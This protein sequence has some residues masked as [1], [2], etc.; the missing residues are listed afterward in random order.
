MGQLCMG[1]KSRSK[2]IDNKVRLK[3]FGH[4][5]EYAAAQG[6]FIDRINGGND[7]VHLLISPGSEHNV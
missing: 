4:I 3:L 6:I 1:K 5:K 7:H 2:I